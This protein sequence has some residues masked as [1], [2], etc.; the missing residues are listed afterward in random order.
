MFGFKFNRSA[1]A[2]LENNAKELIKLHLTLL[3]MFEDE[4]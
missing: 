3:L 2:K 4:N 1:Y